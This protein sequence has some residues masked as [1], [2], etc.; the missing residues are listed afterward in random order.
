MVCEICE[1]VICINEM[2]DIVMND[3]GQA[4]HKDCLKYL[5]EKEKENYHVSSRIH[6]EGKGVNR[7]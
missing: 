7:E 1:S 5:Q 4:F 6:C 2:E 3:K